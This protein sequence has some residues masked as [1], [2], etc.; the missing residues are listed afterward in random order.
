MKL[1]LEHYKEDLE[2]NKCENE[3]IIISK[4]LEKYG[5]DNYNEIINQDTNVDVMK[6]LSDIRKNIVRW[7]PFKKNS[8]ILEIG[9]HLGEVTGELCEKARRV[10]SIEFSNRRADAIINRHKNKENLE[11]I[12]ANF[13]EIELKET[14]DYITLINV[15]EYSEELNTKPEKIIEHA[16]KFLNPDGRILIV[17]DNK[18]GMRSFSNIQRNTQNNRFQAISNSK[19]KLL[20]K[21]K[22]DAIIKK[23]EFSYK[24][25]Y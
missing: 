17:T 1:N 10:V 15:L 19:N 20:T 25:Y 7:Y 13:F 2:Y 16:K 11:L 8:S 24:K 14:F 6:A 4:Y 9:A 23:Q 5:E 3:E 21:G 22:L 12:I 18:F